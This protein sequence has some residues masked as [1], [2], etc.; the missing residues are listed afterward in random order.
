MK[1]DGESIEG[2]SP[3]WLASASGNLPL[4]KLLV[5]NNANVNSTTKTK[6]S[7]LRA[8][9][10]DNH[11]EIVKYLVSKGADV[12]LANR[13]GHTPLMIASFKGHLDVVRYLVEECGADVDKRSVKGNT[14]LHDSAETD[15]AEIFKVLLDN[16]A[17]MTEDSYKNTPL[18]AAALN[19]C[20]SIIH[21]IINYGV[22]QTTGQIDESRSLCSEIEKI[23]ALELMGSTLIDKKRDICNGIYYWKLAFR[24]R[25]ENIKR[26]LIGNDVREGET[27]EIYKKKLAKPN[28]A[29]NYA[30]EF[31]SLD[32]LQQIAANVDDVRMQSL[33]IRERIL[34]ETHSDTTYYIRFRGAVYA[35][36]VSVNTLVIYTITFNCLTSNSE[37]FFFY[38]RFLFS[39]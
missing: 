19:G 30:Q 34:G 25:L 33:L 24:R 20:E 10:Y 16:N 28:S 32:E 37:P 35:D 38:N 8:A 22:D 17:K 23:H 14:A 29:Y 4:V 15:N 31:N 36:S 7:P 12:E 39:F 6:S 3:L 9:C 2:A 1:F 11:L 21:L 18:L 27:I 26:I 13:H 5:E